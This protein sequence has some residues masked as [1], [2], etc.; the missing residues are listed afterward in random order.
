ML[1]DLRDE[2]GPAARG[3]RLDRRQFGAI[4]ERLD[5]VIRI[6]FQQIASGPRAMQADGTNHGEQTVTLWQFRGTGDDADF[7]MRQDDFVMHS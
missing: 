2:T 5:Q 1:L 7:V 4:K 3:L 6:R